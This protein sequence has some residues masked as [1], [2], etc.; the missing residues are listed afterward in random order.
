M[1]IKADL[2]LSSPWFSQSNG[3]AEVAVKQTKYLLEKEPHWEMFSAA[4][5]EYRS[6]PRADGTCLAEIFYC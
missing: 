1:E 2:D 3:L 6:V 4:L 5:A